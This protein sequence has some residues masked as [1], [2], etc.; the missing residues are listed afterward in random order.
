MIKKVSAIYDSSDFKRD[1]LS[2][3]KSIYVYIFYSPIKQDLGCIYS[4][5]YI[6]LFTNCYF[7]GKNIYTFLDKV[8]SFIQFG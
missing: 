6:F 8:S 2:E 4:T 3:T 1:W 7:M 5:V